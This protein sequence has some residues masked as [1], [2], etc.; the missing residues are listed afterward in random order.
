[1]TFEINLIFLIESFFQHDQKVMTKAFFIIFKRLSRKQ[2][3]ETFW[4]GESLTLSNF[5]FINV[6]CSNSLF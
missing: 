2:I 3:T 6:K 4:E 1:M 5:L